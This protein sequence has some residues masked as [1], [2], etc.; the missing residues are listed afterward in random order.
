MESPVSAV[1]GDALMVLPLD[2]I[3][4]IANTITAVAVLIAAS[5]LKRSLTDIRWLD[6]QPP[7][8]RSR[9]LSDEELEAMWRE[10]VRRRDEERGDIS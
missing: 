1:W 7:F 8:S 9:P 5:R 4:A 6:L 3:N 10:I 2:T